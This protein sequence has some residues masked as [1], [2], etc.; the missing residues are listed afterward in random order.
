VTITVS[1]KNPDKNYINGPQPSAYITVTDTGSGMN[2]KTQERIFDPFFTTKKV[3]TGTGLG[4]STV[5]GTMIDHGGTI[6]CS[7]SIGKGTT[8]IIQLPLVVEQANTSEER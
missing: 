1:L 7:S 2:E 4:L 8:F 6:N 3:G 5:Y